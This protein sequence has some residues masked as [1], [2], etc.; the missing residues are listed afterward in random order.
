MVYKYINYSHSSIKFRIWTYLERSRIY[1]DMDM[2]PIYYTSIILYYRIWN[3]ILWKDPAAGPVVGAS[4]GAVGPGE[5]SSDLGDANAGHHPWGPYRWS[6]D[7]M[8]TFLKGKYLLGIF[9]L[10]WYYY[11][12]VIIILVIIIIIYICISFFFMCF[13]LF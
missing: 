5:R 1:Y 6:E 12:D 10:L 2:D 9:I 4:A 7:G 3:P 13:K 8:T 11:Y